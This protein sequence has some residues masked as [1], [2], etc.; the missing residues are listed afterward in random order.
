MERL[1]RMLDETDFPVDKQPVLPTYYKERLAKMLDETDFPTY[2]KVVGEDGEPIVAGPNAT[3]WELPKGSRPGKWTPKEEV[4]LCKSGWHMS[5][6]GNIYEWIKLN[7]YLY[8]AEGRGK[9]EETHN[10]QIQ[11]KIVFEEARLVRLVGKITAFKCARVASRMYRHVMYLP[12]TETVAPHHKEACTE[13]VKAAKRKLMIC[14]EYL[15]QGR[16]V[17]SFQMYESTK[18]EVLDAVE[19]ASFGKQDRYSL[20]EQLCVQFGEWL[21][22]EIGKSE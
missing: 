15:L 22:E 8:V 21:V 14:A 2:Y 12:E 11:D 1:A 13:N 9:S 20:Q 4:S 19:H 7:G 18:F 5:P 10:R 3:H 6:I 16:E 17:D